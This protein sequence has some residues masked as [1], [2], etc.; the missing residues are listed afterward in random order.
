M[1]V[2][3]AINKAKARLGIEKNCVDGFT[4][5]Q[6]DSFYCLVQWLHNISNAHMLAILGPTYGW[7]KD[8]PPDIDVA[9]TLTEQQVQLFEEKLAAIPEPT[10]G[11][12]NFASR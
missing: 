7:H 8:L 12:Y 11:L 5:G 4:D 9:T 1:T 3:D 10:K 2:R 6:L